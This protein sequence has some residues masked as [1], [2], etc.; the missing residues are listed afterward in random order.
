MLLWPTDGGRCQRVVTLPIL[1]S[2]VH[3]SVDLELGRWWRAIN[4]ARAVMLTVG[5]ALRHPPATATGTPRPPFTRKR[6]QMLARAAL[7]PKPRHAVF[8]RAA[9]QKLPELALH[10]LRQ[11]RAVADLR[12]RAQ[13]TPPGARR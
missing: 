2:T 11:A 12:H 4:G 3:V 5:G 1:G 10:E 9:R 8:E 7:A 6:H 13:E